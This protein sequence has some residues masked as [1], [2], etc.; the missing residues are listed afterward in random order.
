M[1]KDGFAT[2][3]FDGMSHLFAAV[4]FEIVDR[5]LGSVLRKSP[6]RR[7]ADPGCTAGDKRDFAFQL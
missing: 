2:A 7:T 5:D 6:R 3:F 1:D 4:D